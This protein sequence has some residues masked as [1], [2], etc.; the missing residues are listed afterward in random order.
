M[1]KI[2]D[3]PVAVI[4]RRPDGSLRTLEWPK[5]VGSMRALAASQWAKQPARPDS[6][7]ATLRRML[8]NGPRRVRDVK[9]ELLKRWKEDYV[10]EMRRGI[11]VVTTRDEERVH[12]WSLP[13]KEG[14]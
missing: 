3:E 8:A 4:F 2:T 6:L 1:T 12:W 9:P 13:G 14:T 11:G 7:R 5:V 10:D